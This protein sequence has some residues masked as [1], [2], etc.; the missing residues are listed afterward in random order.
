MLTSHP[1]VACHLLMH[2]LLHVFFLLLCHNWCCTDGCK[3]IGSMILD[4]IWVTGLLDKTMYIVSM[5]L[6]SWLS[7]VYSKMYVY[8]VIQKEVY[9]FKNLF[10]KYYWTYGNVLYT[11]WRENT[12]VIFTPYKHSMWAPRVM[13]QMSNW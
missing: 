8:K 13:R 2:F 12:K 5:R 4:G 6:I 9:T 7:C 10:Y 1:L 11:D 3:V